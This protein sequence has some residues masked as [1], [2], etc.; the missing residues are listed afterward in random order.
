MNDVNINSSVSEL[1]VEY[2]NAIS[3]INYILR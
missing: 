3:C 2:A 1:E